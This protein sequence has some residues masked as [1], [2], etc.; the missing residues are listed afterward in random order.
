MLFDMTLGADDSYEI[1][2]RATE[3]KHGGVK[4]RM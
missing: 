1:L 2:I 4:G 3:D